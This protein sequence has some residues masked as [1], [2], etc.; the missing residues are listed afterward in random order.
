[1]DAMTLEETIA[2]H[3]KWIDPLLSEWRV[4]PLRT[5]PWRAARLFVERVVVDVSGGLTEDF[6]E[7]PWFAIIYHH[8]EQWYRDHYGAAFEG[9]PGA[10]AMGVVLIRDI[11]VQVH[12]P[13]TTVRVET[14]GETIWVRF[15]NTV[16]QD[17]APL[18][19]L[20][21]S[22]NLGRL[23]EPERAKLAAVV[24]EVATALRVVNIHLMAVEP[25][26]ET[27]SGFVGGVM[28]EL[29]TAAQ[30]IQR[31]DPKQWGS[32]L[33]ALQM[34]MERTL[35]GLS[36][37]QRGRFRESHDLFVLFDDVSFQCDRNLLKKLPRSDEI[38]NLR[39]GLGDKTNIDEVIDAYMAALS[40]VSAAS[41]SFKRKLSFGGGG[42][43]IRKPP[44]I[45]LP[46]TE[47]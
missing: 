46:T 23:D 14:P 39:Y 24:S 33:W 26:D 12:V 5:R 37:Q 20:V 28:S 7:Q 41:R 21:E 6:E 43:L 16:E 40:I 27:I 9:N 30:S 31:D 8:V 47:G 2:S 1:M 13:L 42:I 19:W 4:L 15:P 3:M 32:A 44:W 38:M 18:S 11:P 35:K 34:T 45:T 36:Q 25:V 10:V 29:R 17:E 22:P